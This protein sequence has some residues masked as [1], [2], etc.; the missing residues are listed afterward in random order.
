MAEKIVSCEYA[1]CEYADCD[2]RLPV[3]DMYNEGDTTSGP[4]WVCKICIHKLDDP[5]GYC[6]MSCILG[7]GCDDSC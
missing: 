3:A 4:V 1:D 5:S 7:Y 2:A 6:S